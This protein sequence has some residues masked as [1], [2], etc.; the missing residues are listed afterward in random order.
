MWQREI[1]KYKKIFWIRKLLLIL[2]SFIFSF[3]PFNLFS[4]SLDPPGAARI[5]WIRYR[6][7]WGL[8]CTSGSLCYTWKTLT[9]QTPT[10]SE[11][12][13]LVWM[14]RNSLRLFH[15]SVCM[16]VC[17]C[18]R[19][20]VCIFHLQMIPVEMGA[21]QLVLY[22]CRGPGSLQD[23]QQETLA[24]VSCFT[25]PNNH[26]EPKLYLHICTSART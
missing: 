17:V 11:R 13:S 8:Q 20:S 21:D 5:P 6:I 24:S 4:A 3:P 16:C 14:Y 1:L 2:N 12:F 9:F 7:I 19:L 18:A 10:T 15:S 25:L 22:V 26:G 23:E